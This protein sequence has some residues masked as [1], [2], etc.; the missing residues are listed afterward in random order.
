[1]TSRQ[2]RCDSGKPWS[3]MT[4]GLRRVPGDRDVEL[5]AGRQRDA[6]QVEVGHRLLLE[7]HG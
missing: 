1:M 2:V 7:P 3:R 6:L 5:D 4:G